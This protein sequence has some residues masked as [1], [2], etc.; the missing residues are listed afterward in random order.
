MSGT[1]PG[2]ASGAQQ[3]QGANIDLGRVLPPGSRVTVEPAEHD[4][5]RTARLRIEERAALI[6][7]AKEIAVFGVVLISVLMVGGVYG[8]ITFV[9]ATATAD[10]VKFAQTIFPALV[11]GGSG[12]LFGKAIAK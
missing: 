2:V 7:D 9:S 10:Q 5:D 1:G 12:L 6:K 3:A 11:S 4:A 8:Y